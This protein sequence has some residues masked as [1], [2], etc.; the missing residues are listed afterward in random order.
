[1]AA[2]HGEDIA[3]SLYADVHYFYSQPNAQ[4][5]HHRFDKE[6]Y[7]YLFE[8][9]SLRR[10]RIEIANHAGTP[11]QDA[12]DGHLDGVRLK[13]SYNNS[14][15]VT[16]TV[17]HCEGQEWHLPAFDP[18]NERKYMYRLHTVDIYFWTFAYAIQ[19]VN[20]IRRVLH[21]EQITIL[22][23]PDTPTQPEGN[24]TPIVKRLEDISLSNFAYPQT[25][26]H[27]QGL[28]QSFSGPPIS[29]TPQ[30]YQCPNYEPLSYNPAAPAAP[31]T[32][33]PREKTPPP[34]DGEENHFMASATFGPSQPMGVDIVHEQSSSRVLRQIEPT[35]F[36]EHAESPPVSPISFPSSPEMTLTHS[37]TSQS[38]FSS[39]PMAHNQE[40]NFLSISLP[41]K[42][43]PASQPSSTTAYS[44]SPVAQYA[45]YPCSPGYPRA[46]STPGHYPMGYS[47]R[48]THSTSVN[49]RVSSSHNIHDPNN[50]IYP[51]SLEYS[52]HRQ[53][54]KPNE[55]E[56]EMKIGKPS[57]APTG[58]LE[59]HASKF[60]RGVG[61]LFKKLEKKIG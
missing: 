57:K 32:I 41:P 40:A 4:P 2:R 28:R 50:T 9:A 43:L 34:E 3:A 45:N 35:R 5:A 30:N 12:F 53:I 18:K 13:Y 38:P 49:S 55:H 59:E 7:V 19:F 61:N 31:E 47:T 26:S 17:D 60:E 44:P 24:I 27:E 22:N 48:S 54:Y 58:K 42:Y 56:P 29:A 10:A 6:S 8:N 16:L 11:D 21:P 1:M 39:P 36:S 15:L 25:Q 23:E 20:G 51:N 37:D 33:I 52:M 46:V 14:T